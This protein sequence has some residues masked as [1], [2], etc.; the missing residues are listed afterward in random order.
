MLQ[1]TRRASAFTLIELLVVIAIIAILIALLFPA[2]RKVE[3]NSQK[4]KCLSNL[5]QI[6]Q[7]AMTYFGE[8]GEG[9]PDLGPGAQDWDKFGRAAANLMPYVKY[10]PEVFDC[11]ANPGINRESRLEITNAPG[12]YTEYEFNGFIC[13]YGVAGSSTRS[14]RQSGIFDYSQAAYAWD[15]P[16]DPRPG[17]EYDP[18][19]DRAHA[20]GINVAYLDGHAAWLPDD[21][22]GSF[23]PANEN[24]FYNKGHRFWK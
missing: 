8:L 11:P 23:S 5:R 7:A 10:Q 15:F 24:T 19:N 2:V 13:V 21:Q 3:E 18:N 17:P 9:L 20:G 12:H 1:K 22:M 6:A 4:T 14:R 16:Y